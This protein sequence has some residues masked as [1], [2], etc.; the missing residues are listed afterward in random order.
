MSFE[1]EITP[2]FQREA[3]LGIALAG[4]FSRARPLFR[5]IFRQMRGFLAFSCRD[6]VFPCAFLLSLFN[7]VVR[8][9]FDR[10]I[11]MLLRRAAYW[12]TFTYIFGFAF[13]N[14]CLVEGISG[15]VACFAFLRFLFRSPFLP[16]A[17]LS[18]PWGQQKALW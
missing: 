7:Q 9:V 12:A 5:R 6:L 15:S 18:L 8:G 14:G 10:V 17:F 2:V 11:S 1:S 13:L 3:F 16:Y 4:K